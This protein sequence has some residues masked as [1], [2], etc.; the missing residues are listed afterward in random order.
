MKPRLGVTKPCKAC[1]KEFY[2]PQYRS[3]I[4]VYCSLNCQNKVIHANKIHKKC[5]T[6]QKD[7]TLSNSR[8]RKKYC[9]SFCAISP[10]RPIGLKAK[11]E[12]ETRRNQ[13][14]LQILKRGRNFSRDIRR[15]VWKAKLPICEICHTDYTEYKYCLDIHH[16]D[17]D[18]NNNV[19]DNLAVLCCP[20]HRK[21]HKGDVSY[22]NQE[23][24]IP[25]REI[26][27]TERGTLL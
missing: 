18:P 1:S 26:Q 8:S 12:R 10:D 5:L 13:K 9:S 11:N 23:S 4:A 21:L 6:C 16:I 25:Q 15:I 3:L 14:D 27:E 22:G 24:Q 2:V 19:I 7:F 17:N 20:C